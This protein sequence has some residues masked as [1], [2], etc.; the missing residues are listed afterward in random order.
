MAFEVQEEVTEKA[1]KVM[2]KVPQ[3]TAE[4]LLA[5]LKSLLRKLEQQEPVGKQKMSK[6]MEGGK[7]LGS[8][9]ITSAHTKDVKQNMAV[10]DR[11]C[12]KY[13]VGYSAVKMSGAPGYQV[14]FRTGRA[15]QM[16]AVIEEYMKYQ[17]AKDY[18]YQ[19]PMEKSQAHDAPHSKVYQGEYVPDT[20]MVVSDRVRERKLDL[21]YSDY[22]ME[23]R[24]ESVYDRLERAKREIQQQGL[25]RGELTRGKQHSLALPRKE[26]SR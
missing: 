26:H 4:M 23:K 16:K 2:V 25:E 12:R 14:F 24:R 10:F 18:R 21:I 5:A 11:L 15:D 13:G 1:F 19:E 3:I 6:L 9:E 8:H 7:T 22:P 17:F 20:A